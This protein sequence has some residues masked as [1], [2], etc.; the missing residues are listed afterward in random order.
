MY[1]ERVSPYVYELPCGHDFRSFTRSLADDEEGRHHFYCVPCRFPF[2]IAPLDLI[3]CRPRSPRGALLGDGEVARRVDSAIKAD[4]VAAYYR[5][6]WD[7]M[8]QDDVSAAT[9]VSVSTV[10]RVAADLGVYRDELRSAS[11]RRLR[12]SD[13]ASTSDLTGRAA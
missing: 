4:R 6:V 10:E 8:T 11:V 7:D 9:G 3:E 5:L 1:L 2:S 13:S 12:G